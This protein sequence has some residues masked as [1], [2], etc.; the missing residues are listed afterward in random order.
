MPTATER[1][2]DQKRI[3]A[4]LAEECHLPIGEVAALYESERAV[5]ASGARITRYLHIFAIRKVLDVLHQ[6]DLDRE[7][8]HRAGSVLVAA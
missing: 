4:A 3:V 8:S 1:Q 7:A 6:R 5:L 2:P